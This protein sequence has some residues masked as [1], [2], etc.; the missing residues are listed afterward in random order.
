[1]HK[2]RIGRAAAGVAR[3]A[4]SS[5]PACRHRPGAVVVYEVVIDTDDAPR[6]A[7]TCS[8]CDRRAEVVIDVGDDGRA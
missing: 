8:A 2:A 5:C 1:M 4:R 7:A 6:P 3:V